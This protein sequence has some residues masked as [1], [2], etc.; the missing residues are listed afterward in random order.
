MAVTV[1]L[2]SNGQIVVPAAIRRRLGLEGGDILR[3]TLEEDVIRLK[4]VPDWEE[5]F[6]AV[7]RRGRKP[8]ST[9]ELEAIRRR[10]A[11]G[12]QRRGEAGAGSA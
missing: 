6:A 9:A 5:L 2:S 10:R 1:K 12:R 3:V 8:P 11:V 4:P 7:G